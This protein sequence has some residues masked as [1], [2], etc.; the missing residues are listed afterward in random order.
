[1]TRSNQRRQ[2]RELP[3][4]E[5]GPELDQKIREM[6]MIADRDIAELHATDLPRSTGAT[7]ARVT[8]REPGQEAVSTS[9]DDRH[10]AAT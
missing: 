5:L 2:Y 8:E 6:V 3:D 10:R 1:M 9:R 4:L 7:H